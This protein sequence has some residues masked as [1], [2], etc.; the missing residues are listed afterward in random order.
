MPDRRRGLARPL[1][2]GLAHHLDLRRVRA[3]RRRPASCWGSA[4]SRWCGRWATPATQSAGLCEC[5][6][7]PAK[8]VS[9]GNAARNGLWSA[10]LAE[11]GFAGPPEPLAGAQGFFAVM[12]EPA[13]WSGAARR[14]GQEL[15]G[16]Q[17]LDQALSLG[18]RDPSAARPARSTGGAPIPARRSR[19]CRARG[20]PLLLQRTDRP[21]ITTGRE[22]QVSLQH[23]VAAALVRGKAGLAQFTD[24]CVA[25]PAISALR[26]KVEVAAAPP[27]DHRR[28]DGH[29][30]RRRPH[31]HARHPGRARQLGQPAEGFGDRGQA[32]RRSRGLAARATTSSR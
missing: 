17:Q 28:R 16:R 13:D 2:E 10:L 9:V 15:A 30:H 4:C 24:A 26:R 6:G 8:S 31:P 14:A 29:R 20:N 3:R 19:R 23:A 11:K 21:E 1:P 7:W 32:P 25:D 12:D 27:L 5:L 22:S 18:L